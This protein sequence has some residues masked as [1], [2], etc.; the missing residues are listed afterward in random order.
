VAEAET[1]TA[2]VAKVTGSFKLDGY[3]KDTFG[4]T[5]RKAFAAEYGLTC[6]NRLKP[7]EL[8]CNLLRPVLNVR[9]VSAG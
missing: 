3:T 5:E 8:S 4:D 2:P 9:G 1:T 7:V 6:S